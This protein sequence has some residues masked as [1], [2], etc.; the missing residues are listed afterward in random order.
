MKGVLT[1][2]RT[3]S[4]HPASRRPDALAL[5]I[6]VALPAERSAAVATA[7]RHP[8]RGPRPR[9]GPKRK[10]NGSAAMKRNASPPL[11]YAPTDPSTR[12]AGRVSPDRHGPMSAA[13]ASL[14]IYRRRSQ[15]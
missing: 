4:A 7:R 8:G 13:R 14:S 10:R 9:L 3:G 15:T 6:G 2:R 11:V 5:S 12:A 1:R